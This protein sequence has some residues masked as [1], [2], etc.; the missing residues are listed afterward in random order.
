MRKG[1]CTINQWAS[2]YILCM[3]NI[4]IMCVYVFQTRGM[5]QFLDYDTSQRLSWVGVCE[6]GGWI[7]RAR[8]VLFIRERVFIHRIVQHI[9]LLYYNNISINICIREIVSL[10]EA[11][12][13]WGNISTKI[14]IICKCQV[15]QT[16]THTHTIYTHN[17]IK[18]TGQRYNDQ[19]LNFKTNRFIIDKARLK[20]VHRSH[21]GLKFPTKLIYLISQRVVLI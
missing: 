5:H 18:I 6:G 4:Y 11:E 9:I 7:V 8:G 14:R 20:E 12:K 16:H 17:Y 10:L 2:Q 13:Y 21:K 3:C 15:T 19:K 1:I